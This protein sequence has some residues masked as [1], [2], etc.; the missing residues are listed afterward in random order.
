MLPPNQPKAIPINIDRSKLKTKTHR[1]KSTQPTQN[2][3][4][5]SEEKEQL[6][7]K[8]AV[9]PRPVATRQAV[10]RTRYRMRH[11]DEKMDPEDPEIES[12]SSAYRNNNTGTADRGKRGVTHLSR[13]SNLVISLQ[14]QH[15]EA[16]TAHQFEPEMES[17]SSHCGADTFN[18]LQRQPRGQWGTH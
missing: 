4:H 14:K 5:R 16:C 15:V 12:C 7:V 1:K 18:T 10:E 6:T 17:C 13:T 2:A 3:V 9:S 11:P 8:R